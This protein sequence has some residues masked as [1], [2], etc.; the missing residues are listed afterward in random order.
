M[1]IINNESSWETEG[2]GGYRL[3]EVGGWI[4]AD[5]GRCGLSSIS[6]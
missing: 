1:V 6:L 5:R 3:R 4:V 2:E